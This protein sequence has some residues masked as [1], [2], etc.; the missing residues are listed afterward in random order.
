MILSRLVRP[1]RRLRSQ[2]ERRREEERIGRFFRGFVSPED[3]VFDVGANMGH[4]S[5]TF[6]A[7][8]A[9]V[10]C[11]EP[12]AKCFEELQRLWADSDRVT[13]VN[14]ALAAEPGTVQLIQSDVHVLSSC[15]PDWLERVKE[16][17]RFGEATWKAPIE[18]PAVTLDSLV[19][20]H[21]LPKYCKIDVEGFELEVLRGLSRPVPMVSIEF[22]GEF[23][24]NTEKCVHRLTEIAGYR[25]NYATGEEPEFIAPQWLSATELITDL[26]S[27]DRLS[28]GD[29][30]ARLD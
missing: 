22:A 30:Y 15:S 14:R 21:G 9:R 24:D 16:S 1:V 20:E 25:F 19:D 29:V 10:V 26:R 7:V 5:E 13:L 11:I 28:W 27:R 6:L 23:L 12:Q 4:K 2:Y 18:V 3:L 8:G 17:G